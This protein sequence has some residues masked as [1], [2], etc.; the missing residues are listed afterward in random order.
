MLTASVVTMA[1]HHNLA[2]WRLAS[3]VLRTAGNALRSTH[4]G[5]R[6]KHSRPRSPTGRPCLSLARDDL[7]GTTKLVLERALRI[8]DAV[9]LHHC[10]V[11]LRLR[12]P[13]NLSGRD[14]QRDTVLSD[15]S[16]V[17]RVDKMK[18]TR[19]EAHVD[20]QPVED[21]SVLVREH[22]LH[23]ADTVTIRADPTRATLKRPIRHWPLRCHADEHN[24]RVAGPSQN[25][26]TNDPCRRWPLAAPSSD[27]Q[28]GRDCSRE[29]A[30]RPFPKRR[31]R[32]VARAMLRAACHRLPASRAGGTPSG[33][34]DTRWCCR[35]GRAWRLPRVRYHPPG[36]RRPRSAPRAPRERVRRPHRRRRH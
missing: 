36:R 35:A 32:L 10:G 8:P 19:T 34:Q 11:R 16:N 24:V 20:H 15:F 17:P 13:F 14:H 22:V 5:R 21:V 9:T 25:T 27:S 31:Q 18:P 26:L 12:E 28:M 7:P 2:T 33:G 30:K 23:D 4:S 3:R 6:A 1:V 29:A